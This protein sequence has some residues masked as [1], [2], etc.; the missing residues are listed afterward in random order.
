[1]AAK[2]KKSKKT[3][4]K[5]KDQKGKK[6]QAAQ[7]EHQIPDL[8]DKLNPWGSK[9]RDS[10]CLEIIE[11]FARG[12]TRANFCARHTISNNTFEAWRKKHYLFDTAY[13]AA[14]QKAQSFYDKLR[15]DHL[16]IEFDDE[17]KPVSGLNF[18]LF[19]RMYNTRFNIPDKRAVKVRMLKNAKSERDMLEAMLNAVAEGELTPDEAQKLA[20]LIDIS[21]KVTTVQDLEKRIREIEEAQKLG[22]GDDDFED[23]NE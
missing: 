6:A 12:K 20:N 10:M 5:R 16:I 11:M 8:K 14:V 22:F 23:V 3:T 13:Q 9:Y 7:E 1:M 2:G 4:P 17:G 15:Q 21:I 19:N 18:A